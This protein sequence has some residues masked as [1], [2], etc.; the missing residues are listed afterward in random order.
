M[1]F[2]KEK[3]LD[4]LWGPKENI[5]ENKIY[6]QSRWSVYHNMVFKFDGKFYQTSYSVGATENQDEGPWEYEKEVEC[7]EVAP[8]EVMV[9][10][11]LPV[12]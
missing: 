11:Y 4:I 6:D 8:K 5:M 2:S 9:V 7:V 10:K 1:I 3:L 12:V